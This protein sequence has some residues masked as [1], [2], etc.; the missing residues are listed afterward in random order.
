[1]YHQHIGRCFKK[2]DTR[3]DD[4]ADRHSPEW[5][6]TLITELKILLAAAYSQWPKTLMTWLKVL[7]AVVYPGW[8]KT[9]VTELRVLLAAVYS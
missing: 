6:K 7:L 5:P 8:P 1:M 9:L 4:L 2:C 3:V